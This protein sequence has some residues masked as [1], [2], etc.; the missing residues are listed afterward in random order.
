MKEVKRK[1]KKGRRREGEKKE[2][3]WGVRVGVVDLI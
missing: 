2:R 3:Y 1:R